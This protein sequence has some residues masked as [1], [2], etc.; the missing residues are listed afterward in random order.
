MST[1]V[2]VTIQKRY[3]E[4]AYGSMV[5]IM[6]KTASEIAEDGDVVRASFQAD[7]E[8]NELQPAIDAASMAYGVKSV[9]VVR[10]N[11]SSKE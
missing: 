4:Y 1:T 9:E 8:G 11:E 10:G 5:W 6:G 2:V 3:E 7:V